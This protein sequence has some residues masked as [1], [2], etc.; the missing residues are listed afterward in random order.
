M[1][2]GSYR[3]VILSTKSIQ[4]LLLIGIPPLL[5]E[6]VFNS[7]FGSEDC[8]AFARMKSFKNAWQYES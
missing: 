8:S 1:Y 7:V 5:T 6:D 2:L 3:L 4:S